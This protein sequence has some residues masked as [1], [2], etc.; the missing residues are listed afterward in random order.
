MNDEELCSRNMRI[1]PFFFRETKHETQ[2]LTREKIAASRCVLK[3]SQL[4]LWELLP[5]RSSSITITAATGKVHVQPQA[6][7]NN[8]LYT[9]NSQT[10]QLILHVHAL[11]RKGKTKKENEKMVR[12]P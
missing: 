7:V 11:L 2:L 10:Q 12:K 4:I 6:S 1:L 9:V 3:L 5:F 8:S